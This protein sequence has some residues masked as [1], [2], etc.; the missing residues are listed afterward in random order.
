MQRTCALTHLLVV[1]FE[2]PI[3]PYR[4]GPEVWPMLPHSCVC[5]QA[6]GQVVVDQVLS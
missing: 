3:T 1:K 2:V 4:S 6:E 5:V